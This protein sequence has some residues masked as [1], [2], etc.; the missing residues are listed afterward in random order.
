[1]VSPVDASVS[2]I[3]DIAIDSAEHPPAIHVG[4]DTGVVVVRD[5]GNFVTASAGLPKEAQVRQ[6]VTVSDANGSRWVY[7]GSWAWSVWRAKRG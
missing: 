1:M 7:L 6:L 2:G 4:T 3:W 5:A